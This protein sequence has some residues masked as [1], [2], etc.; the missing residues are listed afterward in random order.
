VSQKTLIYIYLNCCQ[1]EASSS[2]RL[3]VLRPQRPTVNTT[4]CSNIPYRRHSLAV[5]NASMFWVV[6]FQDR[7]WHRWLVGMSARR[8]G[9]YSRTV[10]VGFVV[11]KVTVDQAFLPVLQFPLSASFHQCHIVTHPSIRSPQ[12][13]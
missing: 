13:L 11:D 8:A 10:Q 4:C 3:C 7:P 5:W 9:F 1:V 6:I 12:T 2:A